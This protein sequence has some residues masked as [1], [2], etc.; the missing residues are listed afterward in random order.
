MLKSVKNYNEEFNNKKMKSWT[1]LN[2]NN[3]CTRHKIIVQE[4]WL[5]SQKERE[6][7][8]VER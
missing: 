3:S 6:E 1:K 8:R 4:T 7:R 2:N 5:Q